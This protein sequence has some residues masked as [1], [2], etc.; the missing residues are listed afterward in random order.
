[1]TRAT[2]SPPPGRGAV[3]GGYAHPATMRFHLLHAAGEAAARRPGS[4]GLFVPT[5]FRVQRVGDGAWRDVP[6]PLLEQ[7]DDHAHAQLQMHGARSVTLHGNLHWLVQRGGSAVPGRLQVLVF[8][9]AR[10]RFQLMEAPPRRHGE[11]DDL[12]RSRIVVLSNGKLCAVAVSRATSTMEMWVLDSSSSSSSDTPRRWRLDE[13]ISAVTRD[14]R[15]LSRT[16]TSETQVELAHGDREGEE[17]FVR[18]DDG[19]VDA[20]SLR[21]R[22]WT[23]VCVARPKSGS[24]GVALLPH[25][26]S[27]A[28]DQPSFGEASR[29]LDH[30]IDID[31]ALARLPDELIQDI[32][33]R[34]PPRTIVRCLAVCKAWRSAVSAPTFHRA[35]AAHRPAAVVKVTSKL[36]CFGKP[37]HYSKA[38]LLDTFRGRWYRGNVHTTPPSPRGIAIPASSSRPWRHHALTWVVGSWDGVVCVDVEYTSRFFRFGPDL[39]TQPER[40]ERE[41]V[42]WNPLTRACATVP[43]PPGD[44][45]RWHGVIIGAYAHPATMRFHLLRP[46]RAARNVACSSRRP[47][48]SGESETTPG[49]R[50][51]SWKRKKKTATTTQACNCS[52][53]G[54][55]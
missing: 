22:K 5:V 23:R 45:G 36:A 9:P 7:Q 3:I 37:W 40:R 4:L 13:T 33:A 32:L 41:F 27:V 16:F 50:F 18:H 35:H 20:Y 28:D 2:V 42:L 47:S 51:P 31:M 12:A 24:V 38:L 44:R 8:E 54:E 29:L 14:G 10:E 26:E 48:V 30:T 52:G 43:P 34:L 55:P 6:L 19:R 15:D 11:E 1:M 39:G 21:R 17:V 25:R 53:E 46:P 49:A